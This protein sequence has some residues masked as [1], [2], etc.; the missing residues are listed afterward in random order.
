MSCGEYLVFSDNDIKY[1]TGWLDLG[2]KILEANPDKK[3]AFT[4]LRT[5]KQHRHKSYWRG[6]L[7]FDGEKYLKNIRA[8]SN[9]WLIRRKDFDI[10]GGFRNHHIAGSYWTDKFVNS[11][12]EMVTMEKPPLANDMG[13]K[14]G[15]S[16]KTK[17]TIEKVFANGERM[18]INN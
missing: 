15:Y 12:Y 1:E 4:P 16:I 18:R 13:F 6:E 5:D 7:E 11:G 10:I 3:I 2:L 17:A 9:S 8:G 14:K